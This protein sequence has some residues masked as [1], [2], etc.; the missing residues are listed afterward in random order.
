MSNIF[1]NNHKYSTD[2]P[3]GVNEIKFTFMVTTNVQFIIFLYIAWSGRVSDTLWTQC[4]CHCCL[5]LTFRLTFCKQT[6][7]KK[8]FVL[9]NA[10]KYICYL[11]TSITYAYICMYIWVCMCGNKMHLAKLATLIF[12]FLSFPFVYSPAILSGIS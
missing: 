6:K 4:H 10:T 8:Y 9:L 2:F 3:F 5:A 12:K 11:S 7:Y 1:I